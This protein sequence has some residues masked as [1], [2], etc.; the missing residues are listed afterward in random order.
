MKSRNLQKQLEEFENT[1]E[2]Y[3]FSLRLDLSEIILRHLNTIEITQAKLAEKAKT[4]PQ[5]V[6]RVIHAASNCTLQTAADLL[7]ALGI[8]VRLLETHPGKDLLASEQET[9]TATN[10]SKMTYASF[11][12]DA[13]KKATPPLREFR[14]DELALN[15]MEK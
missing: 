5:V 2:G 1:A 8:K 15:V 4:S 7:F 11:S 13:Q 10:S 3:G 14:M 6:T 12:L 9:K